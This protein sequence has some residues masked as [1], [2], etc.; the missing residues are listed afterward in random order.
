MP[1]TIYSGLPLAKALINSHLVE[2]HAKFNI[3]RADCGHG[4]NITYK[5]CFSELFDDCNLNVF[6]LCSHSGDSV[7]TVCR[8]D[9]SDQE[10]R[11]C[12]R[13]A[14]VQVRWAPSSLHLIGPRYH[15]NRATSHKKWQPAPHYEHVLM[16]SHC[17]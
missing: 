13:N 4:M 8:S 16:L 6:M 15:S 1:L 7:A 12:S 9:H 5:T 2:A 14:R 11:G 3:R 10:S 17:D